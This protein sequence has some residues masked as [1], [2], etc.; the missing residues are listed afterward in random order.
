MLLAGIYSMP[1]LSID[2]KMKFPK[3]LLIFSGGRAGAEWVT[4]CS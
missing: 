4:Y 1:G 2:V 3:L